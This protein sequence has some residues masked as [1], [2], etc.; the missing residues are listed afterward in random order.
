VVDFTR[1]FCQNVS[2]PIHIFKIGKGQAGME[3]P[4]SLRLICL[5]CGETLKVSEDRY[6]CE[7]CGNSYS[8]KPA[9]NAGRI[10]SESRIQ[11]L[12]EEISSLERQKQSNLKER[13]KIRQ[14]INFSGI[15]NLIQLVWVLSFLYL[16]IYILLTIMTSPSL[17]SNSS[18]LA[19]SLIGIRDRYSE[20][21]SQF[22]HSIGTHFAVVLLFIVTGAYWLRFPAIDKDKMAQK[23]QKLDGEIQEIE[24]KLLKLNKEL[25]SLWGE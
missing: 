21:I 12:N 15:S 9:G 17:A 5:F 1:H 8:I 16:L 2:K 20:P 23:R 3:K 11:Q 25:S 10:S 4:E 24:R 13:L 19:Q 14:R 22:L 6:Y 7:N 18:D